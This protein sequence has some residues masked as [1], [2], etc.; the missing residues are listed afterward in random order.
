MTTSSALNFNGSTYTQVFEWKR[1]EGGNGNYYAVMVTNANSWADYDAQAQ[2]NGGHLLTINSL[3]E[4]KFLETIAPML[5]TMPAVLGAKIVDGTMK[6]VSGPESNSTVEYKNFLNA[7]STEPGPFFVAASDWSAFKWQSFDTVWVNNVYNLNI[8]EFEKN[9]QFAEHVRDTGP[10]QVPSDSSDWQGVFKAVWTRLQQTTQRETGYSVSVSNDDTII[11]GGYTLGDLHGDTNQG[12]SDGFLAKYSVNGDLQW[13]HLLGGS[14][15][16]AVAAT[17]TDKHD[18]VYALLGVNSGYSADPVPAAGVSSPTYQLVKYDPNGNL[19]AQVIVNTEIA[20]RG[21]CVTPEGDV[22]VTGSQGMWPGTYAAYLSKSYIESYG[23]ITQD[24][25]WESIN[26]FGGSNNFTDAVFLNGS[27]FAG[28]RAADQVYLAKY[29]LDGNQTW[30]RSIS[31]SSY[32]QINAIADNSIDCIYV[33]GIAGE[34]QGAGYTPGNVIPNADSPTTQA[35]RDQRGGPS[36]DSFLGKFDLS[37]NLIWIKQFGSDGDDSADAVTVDR[38][39]N[40]YVGGYTGRTYGNTAVIN[41]DAKPYLK[42]FDSDGNVVWTKIFNK[43]LGNVLSM[44]ADSKGFVYG[45]GM[46]EGDLNDAVALDNSVRNSFVMKFSY[47]TGTNSQDTLTGSEGADE[48]YAL[49]GNDT[50]YAGLGDD[51]IIGGDGKGNDRYYGGAGADTVKYTSATYGIVVNLTRGT[52]FSQTNPSQRTNR[53]AANIGSDKIYEIENVIAGNYNDLL[54]GNQLTNEIKGEDGDDRIDGKSG[55][56]VLYGGAGN[57]RLTGGTGNDVMAGGIGDDTLDGGAGMDTADYSDKTT[58]VSV[59][60]ND[61]T[62]A[63]VTVDGTL[64]DIIKNIENI[65]GGSDNDSL[66]GDRLANLLS[67]GGG[68]DTL[69]GAGGIDTL[70]G[71]AGSDT[72]DFSDK[73]TAVIATL[74]GATQITVKVGGAA[75][76]KLINIE[77]LIGGSGNDSLTGDALANILSGGNGNDVLNGAAG[78]DTINGGSGNDLL[79]GGAGNDAINGG[80]NVDTASFA[81]KTTSVVITLSAAAG[82]ATIGTGTETDT[83]TGIE[84]LTGGSGNDAFT[85]DDNNNLLN[86]GAGNDVLNGGSGIDTL[87][88]GAGNDQFIFNASLNGSTNLDTVTDFKSGSDKL[89]LDDAI[90]AQLT[91]G[92]TAGNI[93]VG[94]TAA[95]GTRAYDTNDYLIFDTTTKTLYYDANG[96]GGS[97]AVAFVQLTGVKTL[98]HTDFA[99]I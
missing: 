73:T 49:D 29:S 52:A 51:L 91:A 83:L 63:S 13:S 70:N 61:A 62:N 71:G 97:D 24:G 96:M 74:N 25:F 15:G 58:S 38:F 88:G 40:V 22:L 48:I 76:D 72:A 8:V 37:G 23:N 80:D 93:V 39:G 53:D 84:N 35:E 21:I 75:E 55:N 94:T 77:N 11:V 64:E 16:D 30:T 45:S 78:S 47:L 1:S 6:W 3:E 60:L 98:A 66:T 41:T 79:T 87:T 99:I 27:F 42:V 10:V 57:D 4:Q 18:N 14:G 68:D 59:T 46:V 34:I 86:G 33:A 17:G 20:G 26:H 90:F 65:I 69:I 31:S 7:N 5:V 95:L 89:V 19:I 56:D 9:S 28:G 2:L 92:V 82:T 81:D 32:G 67:G 12:G 50:V 85:G 43:S 44:S 54:S 36:A